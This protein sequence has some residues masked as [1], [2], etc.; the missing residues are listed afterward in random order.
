PDNYHKFSDLGYSI[1]PKDILIY[2][3]IGISYGFV[4]ESS[5]FEVIENGVKFGLTY[6][7]YVNK[8]NIINDSYYEYEKTARLFATELSKTLY[9]YNMLKTNN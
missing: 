3:K 2:S 1:I 9:K 8:N 7:I 6:S 5:F 4:T